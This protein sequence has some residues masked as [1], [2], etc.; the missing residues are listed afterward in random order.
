[1]RI[2]DYLEQVNKSLGSS[3]IISYQIEFEV[4]SSSLALIYGEILFKDSSTL[5]FLELI[6][7][8]QEG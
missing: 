5:E 8:T 7:E 2:D 6:R 1:M 4:K 3:V